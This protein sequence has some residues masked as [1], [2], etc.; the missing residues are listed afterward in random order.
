MASVFLAQGNEKYTIL[1]LDETGRRRKKVGTH[2]K[3]E[4]ESLARILEAEVAQKKLSKQNKEKPPTITPIMT[5]SSFDGMRLDFL[6]QIRADVAI[7]QNV[8]PNGTRKWILKFGR[9]KGAGVS[10]RDAIDSLASQVHYNLT[11][12]SPQE[13]KSY[14]FRRSEESYKRGRPKA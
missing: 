10:I 3:N 12:S 14:M 13:F 6:D 7:S 8:E 2:D 11:P 4:S 1:Y 9:T 5:R